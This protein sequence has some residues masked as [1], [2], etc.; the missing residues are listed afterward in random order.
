[1]SGSDLAVSA[2]R[3]AAT[4]NAVS[5]TLDVMSHESLSVLGIATPSVPVISTVISADL[6]N[7]RHHPVT[8][9]ADE[10]DR[11]WDTG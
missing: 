1:M 2:A 5:P 8:E 10:A 11:V 9:S 7:H 6:R 4:R 3:A